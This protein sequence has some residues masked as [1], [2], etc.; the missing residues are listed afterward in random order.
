MWP[1][2]T[3]MP[4][5]THACKGLVE[6]YVDDA[7][8]HVMGHMVGGFN[9]PGAIRHFCLGLVCICMA[10]E[11]GS[12]SLTVAEII[13]PCLGVRSLSLVS[14]R[15]PRA[16][17]YV[18]ISPTLIQLSILVWVSKEL[19][20]LFVI[21]LGGKGFTFKTPPSPVTYFLLQ[22]CIS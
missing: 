11:P 10:L 8:T 9:I 1:C 12:V 14:V 19:W 7:T 13:P 16:R 17:N 22:G 6:S 15:T 4:G 20:S 2:H 21:N 5:L 18:A 3:Q